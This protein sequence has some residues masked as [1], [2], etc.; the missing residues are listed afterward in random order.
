[1]GEGPE[2]FPWKAFP[3]N[4][5]KVGI[6]GVAG[7]KKLVFHRVPSDPHMDIEHGHPIFIPLVMEVV[8]AEAVTVTAEAVATEG[9][10]EVVAEECIAQ[11]ADIAAQNV[12]IPSS[13]WF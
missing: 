5:K 3:K 9:T 2:V 4:K 6:P 7:P 12:Q 1:M 8:L 10:A 11:G 13:K